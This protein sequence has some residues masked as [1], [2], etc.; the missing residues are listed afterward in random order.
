MQVKPIRAP[1]KIGTLRLPE[2]EWKSH[3][4]SRLSKF[5][6]K[7]DVMELLREALLHDPSDIH[8]N[9]GHPVILEIRD[10]MFRLTSNIVDATEFELF[11]RIIRDKEAATTDLSQSKD[12]DGGFVFKDIDGVFRRLRVNMTALNSVRNNNAGSLVLRPLLDK[13]PTV[14]ATGLPPALVQ[15]CFPKS[16]GVYVVGPTGSG[17]TST[18]GSLIR[19]AAESGKAYHGHLRAYEAPPEFDLEALSSEHLLITQVAIGAPWGL[20]TFAHAVRNAMRAHPV[21][22]MIGEVRDYETVSAVVEA[23]LTGHPVF[24]TIHAD[25][26][27]VAFQRLITRYPSERAQAGMY[28]LISTTEVI[29]AQRL[30]KC[31]D[32]SRAALREWLCFDDDVRK[33]LLG[34]TSPGEVSVEMMKLVEDRNFGQSFGESAR[35]LLDAG[36][37]SEETAAGYGYTRPTQISLGSVDQASGFMR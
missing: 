8:I 16:G 24:G 36:R 32:G 34:V 25:N 26:P 30:V 23:A 11:A 35:Q 31:L 17:K 3:N 12:Y 28:D 6:E 19:F 22:I 1:F 37:I 27:A 5:A 29:I 4:S 9:V 7:V 10:K 20:E 18:F 14:E 21:A 13:P 33:K 15:R 2:L